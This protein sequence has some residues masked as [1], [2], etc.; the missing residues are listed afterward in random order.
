MAPTVLHASAVAVAGAGCLITGRPG[1][2]KSTLALEMI[3]AGATLIADD[4]ACL[5]RHGEALFVSPPPAIA[6][7][8]EV[9]G[10]GLMRLAHAP[11]PLAL[12][13]DLDRRAAAR[14]PAPRY[15]HLLGIPCPVILGRGR[16]GLAAILRLI[17]ETGIEAIE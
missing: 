7:R 10:I 17:L 6:G 9:R 12:L 5:A 16:V 2:G 15:R 3:A 14:L 11:A 1:S 4:R 13:V 8:I